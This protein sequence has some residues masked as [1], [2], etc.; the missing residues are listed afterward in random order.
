MPDDYFYFSFSIFTPRQKFSIMSGKNESQLF[1]I[2]TLPFLSDAMVTKET[3][4]LIRKIPTLKPLNLG[5]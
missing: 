2:L 1:K 3:I 4:G 5:I